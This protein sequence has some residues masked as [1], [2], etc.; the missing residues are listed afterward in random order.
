VLRLIAL[1]R[2]LH[3]LVLVS[4]AVALFL[5][6][7]DRAMLNADFTHILK[8]L[9]GGLGGPVNNSNHGI[10]HDLRRLSA[11]NVTNLY[12]VAAAAAAYAA[13]EGTEAVGLWLGR[14]PPAPQGPALS[15]D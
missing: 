8:D 6:A 13:L 10:V 12:L 14:R 9:Q 2:V 3:V 1:D 5:F 7:H 4:L 15:P 11:V